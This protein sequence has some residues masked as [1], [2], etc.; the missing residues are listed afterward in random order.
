MID[1][2]FS[3]SGRL[4]RGQFWFSILFY[5]VGA[6]LVAA[7]L[8]LLWQVIPGERGDDGSFNVSGVRAIPYLVVIFGYFIVLTWSGICIGIKRYHDRNKSGAWVLIQFV[9]IIGSLWYLIE[10]GF[11]RGTPGPNAY[12]S[13]PRQ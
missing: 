10:T 13:D 5:I 3:G 6:L 7:I 9:P 4:N 1:Y 8:A 11:L 12:G 2:L